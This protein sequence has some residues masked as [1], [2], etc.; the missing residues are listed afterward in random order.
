MDWSKPEWL[1]DER[2]AAAYDSGMLTSRD[3]A[4]NL[5]EVGVHSSC[6]VPI[7]EVRAA[8]ARLGR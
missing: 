1:T 8:L 5:V 2:I 4:G 3:E 6:W 7:A